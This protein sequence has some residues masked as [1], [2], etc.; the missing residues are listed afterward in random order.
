MHPYVNIAVKAARLA[1]KSLIEAMLHLNVAAAKKNLHH[2]TE[3]LLDIKNSLNNMIFGV[4]SK[5]YPKHNF[6]YQL[7]KENNNSEVTWVID[8]LNGELNFLYGIP[9]FAISIAV[10]VENHI[11]HGIV[12]NPVSDELFMAS[13]GSGAK[14]NNKRIRVSVH[15]KI[16]SS[17]LA[18]N[19]E[20][21]CRYKQFKQDSTA[22]IGLP[23]VAN[24]IVN[25]D[26]GVAALQLAYVAAGKLDGY[27]DDNL[28]FVQTAA[29]ELLVK[30]AGG[31]VS[32]RIAKIDPLAKDKIIA[33]NPKLYSDLIK[34]ISI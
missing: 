4:I 9:W 30:E 27:C 12:Y 13:K 17:L 3:L 20:I 32:D 5:A 7:T 33:A 11:E 24:R 8:P 18:I 29:G 6:Q 25:R 15:N 14:L 1:G 19:S 28:N 10:L 21:L 16:A 31:F 26:F 34:L 23:N 2:S 22:N